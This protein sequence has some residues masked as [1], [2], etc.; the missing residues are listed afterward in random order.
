MKDFEIL[1]KTSYSDRSFWKFEDQYGNRQFR[2]FS[3]IQGEM[4]FPLWYKVYHHGAVV[5]AEFIYLDDECYDLTHSVYE[6]FPPTE[7][8]W[9]GLSYKVWD[10]IR[11]MKGYRKGAYRLAVY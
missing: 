6:S 9:A 10:D 5:K 8:R 4:E 3:F 7:S 2:D 1:P 11:A